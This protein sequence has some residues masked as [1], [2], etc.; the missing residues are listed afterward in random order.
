MAKGVDRV[1]RPDRFVLTD[2]VIASVQKYHGNPIGLQ[3]PPHVE[4]T[5][6]SC[7]PGVWALEG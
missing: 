5:L 6:A 7:E 4:L 1:E 3:F 2:N